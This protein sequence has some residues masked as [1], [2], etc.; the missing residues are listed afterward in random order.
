MSHSIRG[1]SH[2]IRDEVGFLLNGL[3]GLEKERF[4][5]DEVRKRAFCAQSCNHRRSGQAAATDLA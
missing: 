5:S 4:F 3:Q 1:Y 2:R